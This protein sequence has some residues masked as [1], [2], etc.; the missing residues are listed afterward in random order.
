MCWASFA[1]RNQQASSNTT[2]SY[3]NR[4]SNAYE[5][6][7]T[8]TFISSFLTHYSPWWSSCVPLSTL[9]AIIRVRRASFV[10]SSHPEVTAFALRFITPT[11]ARRQP[12]T[13]RGPTSFLHREKTVRH[14]RTSGMPGTTLPHFHR[15]MPSTP[16]TSRLNTRAP[17]SSRSGPL[18]SRPNSANFARMCDAGLTTSLM[19]M[20][21]RYADI[22]FSTIS[23]L[24]GQHTML[25]MICG[26]TFKPKP[27]LVTVWN[28]H[29]VSSTCTC[30][31][32]FLISSNDTFDPFW[33]HSR[34]LLAHRFASA[35]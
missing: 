28:G 13:G 14:V 4:T 3:S 24:L 12:H 33:R 30:R 17:S 16:L 1:S 9:S 20:S 18:Q 35:V 34:N 21:S 22:A 7:S 25:F 29:K 2:S 8:H 32:A 31:W 10:W 27:N 26:M 6:A 15:R 11:A 23:F 5:L 19:S